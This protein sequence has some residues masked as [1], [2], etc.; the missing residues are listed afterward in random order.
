MLKKSSPL[1][2]LGQMEPNLAYMVPGCVPFKIVSDG[3]T[4]HS[5]WLLFF[6]GNDYLP[7][8]F[9]SVS[10]YCQVSDTGSV[11]WASS[12]KMTNTVMCINHFHVDICNIVFVLSVCSS[13]CLHYHVHL[14]LKWEFLKTLHDC[15]LLCGDLHIITAVWTDLLHIFFRSGVMPLY[16]PKIPV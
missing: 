13:Q 6:K 3:P 14:H 16:L 15:L 9:A 1:K 8:E 4:L 11:G 12:F 10:F 2:Q 7:L 5:R